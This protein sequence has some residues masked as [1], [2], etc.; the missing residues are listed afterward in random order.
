MDEAGILARS[1]RGIGNSL[2]SLLGG[3]ADGDVTVIGR[4]VELDANIALPDGPHSISDTAA[5]AQ[6]VAD[7]LVFPPGADKSAI[8]Q[9]RQ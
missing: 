5:V 3:I 1:L 6:F 7:V 8:S 2:R 9:V 4:F